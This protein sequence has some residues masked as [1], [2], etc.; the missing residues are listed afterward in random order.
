VV[1]RWAA[2]L[3]ALVLAT[4][5]CASPPPACGPA[6]GGEAGS[7]VQLR[8]L[9]FGDDQIAFLFG[10]RAGGVYGIP[11]FTAEREGDVVRVRMPG[12]RLRNADG[13]PSYH[14]EREVRPPEGR[15]AR[16]TIEEDASEG[17]I[18][19]LRGMRSACPQTAVRRYGLGS[20]HPAALVSVAFRDGPVV[21][22]DPDGGA[23]G[24]PMQVVGLGFT[25]SAPVAF[26]SD[27]RTV[28]TSHADAKGLLDT[29]MYVPPVAPG[30]HRVVI[31]NA[32]RSVASWFR[33]E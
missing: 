31:R 5:S 19:V 27:G 23:P 12:A 1:G 22:F 2:P 7:V 30:L 14:G 3:L 17:V 32:A 29:I 21:V 4:A 6:S 9:R 24:F 15:I 8:G 26:Q 18:M 28:W 25:P 33:A 13:S 10:L 20:T 16:V 11:A